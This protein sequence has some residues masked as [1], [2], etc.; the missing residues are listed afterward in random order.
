MVFVPDAVPHFVL[1]CLENI[2]WSVRD[3]SSGY[4]RILPSKALGRPVEHIVTAARAHGCLAFG[5]PRVPVSDQSFWKRLTDELGKRFLGTS[6]SLADL[7]GHS[8]PVLAEA[9]FKEATAHLS[10]AERELILRSPRSAD[11]TTW[12][13]MQLLMSR[14]QWWDDVSREAARANAA[15]LFPYDGTPRVGF[16]KALTPSEGYDA[17]RRQHMRN[18]PRSARERWRA[19]DSKLL[20]DPSRV[21]LCLEGG[22]WMVLAES[23]IRQDMEQGTPNDPRRNRII[24]LAD[25]LLTAAKGRPC[26][27][28]LFARDASANRPYVQLVE[29]YRCSP[30][31][32]AAELPY[33]PADELYGLAQRLTVVRWADLLGPLLAR[34]ASDNAITARVRKELRRRI[35]AGE[36]A[37][38]AIGARA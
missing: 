16:W 26:A 4:V 24:Q 3:Y 35:V 12:N 11:W 28:W 9:A 10:E 15:N 21:D 14:G 30:E 29:R 7:P 1:V 25:C 33:H 31:M 5:A 22:N 23:R 36:A 38:R 20:E 34:R 18:A 32:F 17:W 8:Y 19:A 2:G 27:L 6:T 37:A 13:A